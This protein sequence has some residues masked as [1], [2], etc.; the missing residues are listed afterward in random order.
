MHHFSY[1]KKRLLGLIISVLFLFF[2]LNFHSCL[3][4]DRFQLPF[5]LRF[6]KDYV[7]LEPGEQ[8]SLKINGV[9]AAATYRS[10][11]SKVASVTPSGV[12]YAWKCGRTVITAT[13]HNKDN[14]KIQC[15]IHVT[16]LNH[17]TMKLSAGESKTLRICGIYFGVSYKSS[18]PLIAS[19]NRFG[20]VT[21]VGRGTVVITALAKGKTFRCTVTVK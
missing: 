14:K 5:G 7:L 1:Y 3:Y 19:V 10:S 15:L 12:V 4:M 17:R 20:K 8:Y 11:R 18:N 2:C 6:A 16:K 13:I 9:W 21:A